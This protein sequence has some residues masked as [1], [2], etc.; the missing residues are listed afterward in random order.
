MI[1]Q[2]NLIPM[3]NLLSFVTERPV[4][5][6]SITEDSINNWDHDSVIDFDT[7]FLK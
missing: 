7:L 3:E 1:N 5:A 4:S 6:G 2:K